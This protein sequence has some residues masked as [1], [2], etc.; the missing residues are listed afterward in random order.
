[1]N[2]VSNTDPLWER[3]CSRRRHRPHRKTSRKRY[4][5][6][7]AVPNS[8]TRTNS[9]ASSSSKIGAVPPASPHS[10]PP[11]A[12]SP[13]ATPHWPRHWRWC[14]RK[15]WVP[16]LAR[17]PGPRF[18]LRLRARPIADSPPRARDAGPTGRRISNPSQA[19]RQR[20]STHLRIA[21]QRLDTRHQRHAM[22]IADTH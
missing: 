17:T 11:P 14:P 3:A 15:P 22:R 21:R 18:A 13:P 2:V 9:P 6:S 20:R 7:R 19:L 16:H 5:T 4:D 10:P 12:P 8:L 1:M